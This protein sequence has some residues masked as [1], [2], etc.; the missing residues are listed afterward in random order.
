MTSCRHTIWGYCH[1][2]RQSRKE[3]DIGEGNDSGAGEKVF[4]ATVGERGGVLILFF[5]GEKKLVI[6]G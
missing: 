2:L 5:E 6:A 3:Y 4:E 1:L